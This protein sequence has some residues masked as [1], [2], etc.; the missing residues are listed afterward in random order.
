M[1]FLIDLELD[2]PLQRIAAWL[3]SPLVYNFLNKNV[4]NGNL[5]LYGKIAEG[6]ASDL[7]GAVRVAS[8]IIMAF[9]TWLTS[10]VI[11]SHIFSPLTAIVMAVED[12][13]KH[14]FIDLLKILLSSV[15]A[16]LISPL[17]GTAATQISVWSSMLCGW[18]IF[19]KL[20]KLKTFF[21][22]EVTEESAGEI[23]LVII[24]AFIL[25]SAIGNVK[26]DILSVICGDMTAH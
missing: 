2:G 10:K 23:G 15:A 19:Y 9:A 5:Y 16:V 4:F 17:A 3:I 14:T 1:N 24:A 21:G 22:M 6:S 25:L 26:E 11:I 7:H 13:T 20:L 18:L 8:I 12:K